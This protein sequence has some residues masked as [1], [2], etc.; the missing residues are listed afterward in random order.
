MQIKLYQI[1]VK[2]KLFYLNQQKSPNE[3]SLKT[4]KNKKYVPYK[5]SEIQSYKN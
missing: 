5:L 3:F 4:K 1:L 2:Q